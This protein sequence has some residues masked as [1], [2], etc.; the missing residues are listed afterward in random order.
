MDFL[1]SILYHPYSIRD[2]TLQCAD[3]VD[4]EY[5]AHTCYGESVRIAHALR[6]STELSDTDLSCVIILTFI[7]LFP[8]ANTYVQ[9]LLPDEACV[10]I[11]DRLENKFVRDINTVISGVV[12]RSDA[13]IE[14]GAS[15]T[16]SIMHTL[17]H[18]VPEIRPRIKIQEATRK[19]KHVN[20][21]LEILKHYEDSA[22]E[23]RIRKLY[24]DIT[25]KKTMTVCG[26][27]VFREAVSGSSYRSIYYLH[28]I[29]PAICV[30][31]AGRL[32]R[33]CSSGVVTG[34]DIGQCKMRN[35]PPDGTVCRGSVGEDGTVSIFDVLFYGGDSLIYFGYEQRLERA[36]ED[37]EIMLMLGNAVSVAG[38]A[39]GCCVGVIDSGVAVGRFD[40]IVTR[41]LNELVVWVQ[42][43][44]TLRAFDGEDVTSL[45]PDPR[46]IPAWYNHTIVM[47][48]SAESI[49]WHAH[50]VSTHY[51]P[52][53]Y[54]SI[55][56][57]VTRKGVTSSV[58]T[59][60]SMSPRPLLPSFECKPFSFYS[61]MVCSDLP[62]RKIKVTSEGFEAAIKLSIS[63]VERALEE[64]MGSDESSLET[65]ICSSIIR[66]MKSEPISISSDKTKTVLR[67]TKFLAEVPTCTA[68]IPYVPGITGVR[69]DPLFIGRRGTNPIDLLNALVYHYTVREIHRTME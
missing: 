19:S 10:R 41:S 31:I 26:Q 65:A 46:I 18:E 33:V 66:K 6:K 15:M 44:D 49:H 14:A 50:A 17:R 11:F 56:E 30:F 55:S 54:E 13:A 24:Q 35:F 8:P 67:K 43:D 40:V 38:K 68:I 45:F 32:F 62:N 23:T 3:C 25:H 22:A 60:R 5:Y 69:G 28:S 21:L 29:E 47:R 58:E 51:T 61:G 36:K 37:E 42:G 64:C 16:S 34:F 12:N 2:F 4:R 48:R 1:E 53:T 59:E 57:V 7:F 39:G 27:E 20:E 63:L 52:D 9:T